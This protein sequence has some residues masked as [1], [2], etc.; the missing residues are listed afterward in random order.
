M[1]S[2]QQLQPISISSGIRRSPAIMDYAQLEPALSDTL[3]TARKDTDNPNNTAKTRKYRSA[4]D[5]DSTSFANISHDL[6]SQLPASPTETK[7]TSS[8]LSSMGYMRY[9][10]S[11]HEPLFNDLEV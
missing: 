2:P 6:M 11:V 5:T 7:N 10:C 8:T 9:S 3:S 1:S 4:T